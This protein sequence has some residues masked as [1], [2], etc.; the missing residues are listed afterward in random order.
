MLLLIKIKLIMK[1]LNI[2]KRLSI[3]DREAR[4]LEKQLTSANTAILTLEKRLAKL[5]ENKDDEDNKGYYILGTINGTGVYPNKYEFTPTD[6]TLTPKKLFE[7][8][9]NEPIY[10]RLLY[11]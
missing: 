4:D 3:P 9:G 1:L 8:Y 5:E 11:P 6:N 2:F 10:V 7:L